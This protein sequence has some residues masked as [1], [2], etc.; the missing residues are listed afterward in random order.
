MHSISTFACIARSLTATADRAG[1]LPFEKQVTYTSFMDT[2]S[3]MSARK[4]VHPALTLAVPV[5]D[6]RQ[7]GGAGST[8]RDPDS[9]TGALPR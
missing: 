3:D 8:A 1:T 4:S 9:G 2:Q 5:D 7:A 6:D